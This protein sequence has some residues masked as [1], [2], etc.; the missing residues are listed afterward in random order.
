MSDIDEISHIIGKLE[1]QLKSIEKKQDEHGRELLYIRNSITN[2]RM[3]LAGLSTIV[4]GGVS[5]LYYLIHGK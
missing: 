3:K 1:G 4:S 5:A 2:N